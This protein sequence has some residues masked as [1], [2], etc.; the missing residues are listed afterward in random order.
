MCVAVPVRIVEILPDDMLLGKVG[1]GSAGLKISALLLPEPVQV[2]DY[3]LVHAGFAMQRLDREQAE[4][5][6]ALFRSLVA[7]ADADKDGIDM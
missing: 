7:A 2:G 6:L 3:V 4:E 1:E 5:T